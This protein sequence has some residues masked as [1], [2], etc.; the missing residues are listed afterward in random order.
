MGPEGALL[1]LAAGIPA[2]AAVGRLAALLAN[3]NGAAEAGMGG[4]GRADLAW[5]REPWRA[6]LLL[7]VGALTPLLLAAAGWRFELFQAAAVSF[8]LLALLLCAATDLLSY[9]VPNAITYPGAALALSAAAV[10]PG[11]DAASSL[12]AALLAGGALLAVAVVTRGGMGLG[13]VKLAVLI[14]AAL[15]LSGAFQALAL[16]IFAAGVI[17]LAALLAG[18]VS[19]KQALPYAPFLSAGAIAVVLLQGASFAPL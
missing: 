14:G 15:G 6:R 1:F 19:R 4:S 3:E 7:A 2:G 9:R 16:G 17:M 8:L 10:L 18:L 11:G 5:Q 12:A 13:D